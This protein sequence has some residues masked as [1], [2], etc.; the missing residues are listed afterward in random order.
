MLSTPLPLFLTLTLDRSR[1]VAVLFNN[2][3]NTCSLR[4]FSLYTALATRFDSSPASAALKSLRVSTLAFEF[5]VHQMPSIPVLFE[6]LGDSWPILG[7]EAIR[8]EAKEGG[9]FAGVGGDRALEPGF[10]E[11]VG[12]DALLVIIHPPDVPGLTPVVDPAA[13]PRERF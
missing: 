7:R 3:F 2:T 10:V 4:I 1:S 6:T 12:V 9:E 5:F 11:E 8:V 13:I